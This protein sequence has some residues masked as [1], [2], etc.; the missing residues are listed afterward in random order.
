MPQFCQDGALL[1]IHLLPFA[2]LMIVV[3]DQMKQAM[4]QVKQQLTC[5]R[6]VVLRGNPLRGFRTHDNFAIERFGFL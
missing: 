6:P 3:S 2:L 5:S 1:S 4:H